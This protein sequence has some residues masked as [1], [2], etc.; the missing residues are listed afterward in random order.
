MYELL[1]EFFKLLKYDESFE[2][3]LKMRELLKRSLERIEYAFLLI[4]IV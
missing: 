3:S 4:I 1:K 2:L